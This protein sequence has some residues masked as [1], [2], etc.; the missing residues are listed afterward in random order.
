[1]RKSFL[2]ISIVTSILG[3][4]C[5]K[6][7]KNANKVKVPVEKVDISAQEVEGG[8]GT[9]IFEHGSSADHPNRAVTLV[10]P[11]YHFWPRADKSGQPADLDALILARQLEDQWVGLCVAN[12]YRYGEIQEQ[13][14]A[15]L[16][17][18]LIIY[19][20][21]QGTIMGLRQAQPKDSSIA[22]VRCYNW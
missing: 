3:F 10:H 14:P 15:A 17:Q 7:G 19:D 20:P 12:G 13:A 9:L 22:K 6:G 5:A 18:W 2:L 1:M 16:G 8:S 21:L 11:H 4:G